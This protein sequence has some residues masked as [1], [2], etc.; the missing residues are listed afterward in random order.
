MRLSG[1]I[2]QKGEVIAF[3]DPKNP[4]SVIP[5]SL[6]ADHARAGTVSA[7]VS[8]RVRMASSE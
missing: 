5:P 7:Q 3:F 6:H 2:D 8:T 4:N 1:G